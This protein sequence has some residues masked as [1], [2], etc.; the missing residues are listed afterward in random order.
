MPLRIDRLA[1][2][3]TAA[4]ITHE[5][6]ED[7]VTRGRFDALGCAEWEAR[8]LDEPDC[9]AFFAANYQTGSVNPPRIETDDLDAVIAFLLPCV[10]AE[11]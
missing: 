1:A 6:L 3:L 5:P 2:A 8:P 10:R 9:P 4:G 7:G 11:S